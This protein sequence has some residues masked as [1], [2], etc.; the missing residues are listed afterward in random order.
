MTSQSEYCH[1][2]T[3][4]YS[5]SQKDIILKINLLDDFRENRRIQII[6]VQ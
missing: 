5:V 3:S 2:P 1:Q 4:P 6:R